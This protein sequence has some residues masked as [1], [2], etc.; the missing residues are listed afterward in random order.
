MDRSGE[1]CDAQ[2]ISLP[3][4]P[5]VYVIDKVLAVFYEGAASLI[6]SAKIGPI[7]R[8]QVL[9]QIQAILVNAREK[10]FKGIYLLLHGVTAIID[11][12]VYPW[13][14]C[15]QLFQERFVFLIADEYFN[16]LLLK[17]LA[18][19]IDVYPKYL[20][21]SPKILFP[22]L[23]RTSLRDAEFYNVNT[24]ASKTGK[25]P[26]IDLKIMVPFVK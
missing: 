3:G 13:D 10:L 16:L 8:M 24:T 25:V 14:L 15:C 20:C 18:M 11:Q 19:R 4:M 22:H 1:F 23:Q 17:F 21:V 2:K 5:G 9:T 12:N 26:I 6:A 7:G